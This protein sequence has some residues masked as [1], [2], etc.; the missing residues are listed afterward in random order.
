MKRPSVT[1]GQVRQLLSDL[2][3]TRSELDDRYDAFVEGRTDMFFALPKWDD[4]RP[5]RES[6]LASLRLQLSYRGLME[7]A[8]FDARFLGA[9]ATQ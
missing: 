2:G 1:C 7:V 6:D 9:L 3:F 5:V 4:D 8:E